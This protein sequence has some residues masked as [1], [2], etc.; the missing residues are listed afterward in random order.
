MEQQLSFADLEYARKRR[1][2]R[3]EKFLTYM[4]GLIP[5][6]T[7]V[8]QIKP[9]YYRNRKGRPPRDPETM[10]RMYFLQLWY[11]L[12]DDAL[13]DAVYDSYAMRRFMR[14]DFIR[15]SVP[16]ATTL[17][18]FRRLL[19]KTGL[20]KEFSETVADLLRQKKKSLRRGSISEP[21]LP[22]AANA[23]KNRSK[24][25]QSSP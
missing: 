1:R 24:R 17:A 5:W 19:Q 6:E 22:A 11:R 23:K 2:T 3:R 12:S 4:D 20:A 10:L 18:R 8:E 7:F 25:G 13:E 16:D 9:V 15:E 14:L 21:G